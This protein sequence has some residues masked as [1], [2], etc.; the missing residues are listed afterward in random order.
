MVDS[1]MVE[2]LGPASTWREVRD[3]LRLLEEIWPRGAPAGPGAFGRFEILRELGRGGFGVVFLALDPELGRRVALKVPRPEVLATPEVRRRFLREAHA[4]SRLDHPNL[5]PVFEAGQVGPVCYLASAYV[6]G[7]TLAAW[8]AERPEPV[9]PRLAA[10]LVATL[11]DAVQHAH[12]R[13]IL[14]RDIKPG[15]VLLQARGTGAAP[16]HAGPPAEPLPFIPR[17]CDFG[18][19]KLSDQERGDTRTGVPLGSPSYMAPEQAEG[20]P[21]AVGPAADLYGL[22]AIL[23]ELVT[24]RPPFKTDSALE[25]LRRVVTEEPERPR[26]LRRGLPRD[27][28]TI[29]LKCLAKRPERRYATAA[30]LAEDLRRFLANEPILARST[31]TWERAWKWGRRRPAHAALLALVL[32]SGAIGVGGLF[33][34]NRLL[35]WHNTQLQAALQRAERGE[36]EARRQDELAERRERKARRHLFGFQVRQAQEAFRA[37]HIELARRLLDAARDEADSAAARGFAWSYLDRLCRERVT[38]LEGHTVPVY[39]LAVSP[40]GK[41]LASGDLRGHLRLWDLATGRSRPLVGG[42]PDLVAILAFSPDGRTLASVTHR[43][44]A[45][46]VL[47]WDVASGRLRAA[48]P[49]DRGLCYALLFSPD[50]A[51][52]GTLRAAPPEA[53]RV[54]LW[55]IGEGFEAVR[56]PSGPADLARAALA[57]EGLQSLADRLDQAGATDPALDADYP[58]SPADGASWRGVALTRDGAIALVGRGDGE[59]TVY[60]AR[61]GHRLATLLL[62]GP[63][64]E[65]VQFEAEGVLTPEERG[66]LARLA[67]SPDEAWNPEFGP[68]ALAPDGRTLAVGQDTSGRMAT[69]IDLD[70]GQRLDTYT[71]GETGAVH[72]LAFLAGGRTLAFGCEDHS[73]RLWHLGGSGES[74]ALAG[75]QAE[76]WSLAFR[77]DGRTLAS[78]A[79]DHTIKLWDPSTGRE[80][81]TL[82]GHESLVTVVAYSPDGTLLASCSLDRT[83]RLWDVASGQERAILRGHT[84]DV[85][86]LA[87][88]PDGKTLATIGDDPAL[89]LWEVATGA[90]GEVLMMD[91]TSRRRRALAWSPD[92]RRLAFDAGP[93]GLALWRRDTG[94]RSLLPIDRDRYTMTLAFSPDGTLLA[95]GHEWGEIYLWDLAGGRITLRGHTQ[96]VLGLAF[97]PDGQTLA[98]VGRDRSIRLWDPLTGQE[99]LTLRGHV[100]QVH[101]VTFSPDGW[102]LAT[103]CH[104][105]GIRLWTAGPP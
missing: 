33:W 6:E 92:G 61:T 95:S 18:L 13:G 32:L 71:F 88:S 27:L 46:E 8:L 53:P 84:G 19:A 14:H 54:Q 40:D 55:E 73:I 39:A 12:D 5:V 4:A 79:D 35:H 58:I 93:E 64:G 17:F 74:R 37:G 78:A 15:N 21:D 90:P 11:A 63:Q 31:P 65:M 69:L 16:D 85:R 29:A 57:G 52:L 26:R 89:R 102:T 100:N 104:G 94:Q 99:L 82:T 45:A 42:R 34:Y 87:F 24:G 96:D 43:G 101:A 67:A 22:G 7:P 1:R 49:A 97:S 25:T 28:E 105:G 56:R 38:L 48:L 36:Q 3:G 83:V 59:I 41:T 2:T 77:P 47:L 20:L 91:P 30:H 51:L 72:T 60:R 9:P 44:A 75:H 76:V 81:A 98:S 103:A 10:R 68:V 70:T 66:R 62:R 86:G 23:Y 50:G 80:R